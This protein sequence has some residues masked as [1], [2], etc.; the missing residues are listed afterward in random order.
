MKV[1]T[2]K[3]MAMIDQQTIKKIGVPGVV[4]ME[5]AGVKVGKVILNQLDKFDS[6]VIVLAGK[7]NNGGDGFVISRFLEAK[8]IKV[9][10]VLLGSKEKVSGDA[11]INLDVLSNLGSQVKEINNKEEAVSLKPRLKAADLI[12]DALLGTGIKGKLRGLY[13]DVIELVNQ[14]PT[15]VIAVDIP[16]GVEAASGKVRD[17]AIEANRTVTLCLPKLGLILYPGAEYTGN[18]E[19]VDIGLP[20]KV[21][22]DQQIDSELITSQVVADFLPIREKKSHKGSFGKLLVVAGSTGM[23]GAAAL[24]GQASLRSGAGLVTVG[25][26]ASLNPILEEKLTEAMTYPLSD[27]QGTLAKEALTEIKD[28]LKKRDLLAIGPG[29]RVNKEISYLIH[30]LVKNVDK[31]LVIDADGLNAL[32]NLKLLKEREKPTILTPH[33]GELARLMGQSIAKIAEDRLE[34]AQK[35]AIKY[36]VYLVLKGVRTV[37]ATP[38]GRLYLNQTGNSG[39]ATGGSGD[40]LTGLIAGLLAQKSSVT[41]AIV[42]AVY[43]H[44]LAADLAVKELTEYS[45]LPSDLV[46]YLPQAIKQVVNEGGF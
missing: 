13:P 2:G 17:L 5:R 15:K 45:L 12:V 36:Q 6:N 42:A 3:Q 41:E 7:G 14:A 44:G 1:V 27:K 18:L 19:V 34:I 40:I 16:S 37:I 38:T 23:T 35:F 26:P 32:D 22:K 46:Q 31:P 25:V 20:K 43:L 33:P 11:K 30:S 21:I 24:T 28:L 8:G 9:E 4:L 29:L 10:T 39:L